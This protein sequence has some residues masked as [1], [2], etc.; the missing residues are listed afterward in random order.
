MR[1]VS[2]STKGGGE[3]ASFVVDEKSSVLL[4]D[5]PYILD[6]RPVLL[7]LPIETKMAL[8]F[9]S[10]V[11]IGLSVFLTCL[12]WKEGVSTETSLLYLLSL[13]PICLFGMALR[14][15]ISANDQEIVHTYCCC[16]TAR[17]ETDK[18]TSVEFEFQPMERYKY[19]IRPYA[20]YRIYVSTGK[21]IEV[22]IRIHSSTDAKDMNF[23][24]NV[25]YLHPF[26]MWLKTHNHFPVRE[27]TL[28]L[29]KFPDQSGSA[30]I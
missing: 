30:P 15:K 8:F 2:I 21:W 9:I 19:V 17:V 7:L 29:I 1:H 20:P 13:V 24:E 23:H 12:D 16:H 4:D 25:E 5:V 22:T 26:L 28:K 10:L 6:R 18:I 27:T 14:W 3:A 11:F